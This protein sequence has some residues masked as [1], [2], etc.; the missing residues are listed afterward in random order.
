[1]KTAPKFRLLPVLIIIAMM[2]FSVRLV[3]FASGIKSLSSPAMAESAPAP[4]HDTAENMPDSEKLIAADHVGDEE[5]HAA[6][7]KMAA[8]HKE[9]ETNEAEWRDSS[10]DELEYSPVTR[11]VFDDMVKRR[12]KLEAH[13]RELQTREALLQA[14]EQELDRKFQELSTLRQ[15]IEG[16]LQKQSEQELERVQSLVKIYEGMKPKEAARIFDTLDLDI[17][18]TVM[19]R[20]SERRLSPILAS[21]NPERARTITIMLAEEKQLPALP[22]GD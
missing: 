17:L 9:G 16:L 10:Y 3:E 21:M 7:K 11:E 15:E 4:V 1:M 6:D 19:S 20:M 8:T 2:A 12:K 5:E 13:E 18:V 22:L 14:A